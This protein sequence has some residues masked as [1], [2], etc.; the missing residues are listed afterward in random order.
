[1]RLTVNLAYSRQI[2]FDYL[3]LIPSQNDVH[4]QS[5]HLFARSWYHLDGMKLHMMS[6][7]G[8]CVIEVIS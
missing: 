2:T 6:F 4:D 3:A 1:M 5:G 7:V 8:L